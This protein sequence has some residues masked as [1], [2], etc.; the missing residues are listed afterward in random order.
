MHPDDFAK[1]GIPD[2]WPPK[3]WPACPSPSRYQAA[4][5]TS[6]IKDTTGTQRDQANQHSRDARILQDLY[7]AQVECYEYINSDHFQATIKDSSQESPAAIGL[8][9]FAQRLSTDTT[10]G[11]AIIREEGHD[12]IEVAY[13]AAAISRSPDWMGLH[14]ALP[15]LEGLTAMVFTDHDGNPQVIVAIPAHRIEPESHDIPRCSDKPN[16]PTNEQVRTLEQVLIFH[17]ATTLHLDTCILD[18]PDPAEPAKLPPFFHN[19]S[20]LDWR[21]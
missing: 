14:P 3:D 7:E 10:I 8:T 6:T 20:P 21:N 2:D 12:P 15:M 9:F 16:H 13:T 4:Q 17:R 1:Y 19:G 11:M 18:H 5:Y